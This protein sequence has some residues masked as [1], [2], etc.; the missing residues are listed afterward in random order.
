MIDAAFGWLAA[1]WH[2]WRITRHRDDHD[3]EWVRAWKAENPNRC[4]VCSYTKWA[5]EK[6]AHLRNIE[7]RCLEGNGGSRK[8]PKA[9]ARTRP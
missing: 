5:N 1:T 4:M 6:G 7:H 8:L 2:R 9:T 3:A